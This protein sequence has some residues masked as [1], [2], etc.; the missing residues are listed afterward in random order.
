MTPTMPRSTANGRLE[1][2]VSSGSFPGGYPS[3]SR[4][5]RNSSSRTKSKLHQHLQQSG[6]AGESGAV[7]VFQICEA[8]NKTVASRQKMCADFLFLARGKMQ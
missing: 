8:I 1:P 2:A 5:A 6:V 7:F 3:R 4:C